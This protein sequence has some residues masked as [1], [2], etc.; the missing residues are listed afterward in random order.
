M[1]TQDQVNEY[2]VTLV[3]FAEERW[4]TFQRWLDA[5]GYSYKEDELEAL[6]TELRKRVGRE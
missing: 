4:A 6:H 1:P 5:S 3:D 2:V